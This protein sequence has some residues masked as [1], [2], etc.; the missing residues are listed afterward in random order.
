MK[1]GIII[2]EQSTDFNLGDDIWAYAALQFLPKCDYI[3]QRTHI[4]RF[5][6]SN[7]ENVAVLLAGFLM[8]AN[9]EHIF[10][11][12]NNILPKVISFHCRFTAVDWVKED[13]VKEYLKVHEPI[14]AR[15]TFT[16]EI[17][18]NQGISTYF[19]G[20]ITMALDPP[21]I[22]KKEVKRYICLVDVNKSVVDKVKHD[23]E[24]L[25]IEIKIMSHSLDNTKM[26]WEERMNLVKKY[27]EIYSNAYCVITSRLHVALPCLSFGTPV[28]TLTPQFNARDAFGSR[29]R[30]YLEKMLH[31][32]YIDEFVSD[33]IN[34]N[35]IWP[36]VN[37]HE[38]M[39]YRDAIIKNIKEWL[40]S[41]ETGEVSNNLC[42][43]Q[44]DR[45]RWLI[46]TYSK[47]LY[48]NKKQMTMYNKKEKTKQLIDVNKKMEQLEYMVFDVD[49]TLTDGL[50]CY[51]NEKLEYKNF[52]VQDGII[53]KLLPKLGITTII[54][55]GRNSEIVKK[56]G[57][58][59]GITKIIQNV[60]NKRK[61]L[62]KL[63]EENNVEKDKIGYIGDDLND[64]KAMEMCGFKACPANAASEIKNIS[65]YV[66]EKIG[67]HGAVRDIVEH[68]LKSQGKWM[69]ILDNDLV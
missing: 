56:R 54:L 11:P 31:W 22:L 18:E 59:L 51:D 69:K 50:I 10:F 67:G 55:T 19:S 28:L 2:S 30:P 8:P 21:Q 66:S 26:S 45:N 43:S 27:L 24:N 48:E 49:G 52:S 29:F 4:N 40:L 1:Y 32:G 14:G 23:V 38:Y 20:C 36:P 46:E 3:I 7:N 25:D 42:E 39:P 6:S 13:K 63:I 65:D 62:Q 41:C 17:F 58:E 34:Y 57:S 68:I 60:T 16:K 15:D 5:Q 12:T 35:V 37:S 44:E 47:K 61:Q 64:Y 53:I 33:K 9:N